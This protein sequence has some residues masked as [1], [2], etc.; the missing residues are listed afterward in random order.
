VIPEI[1][2]IEHKEDTFYS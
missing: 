2:G 1:H